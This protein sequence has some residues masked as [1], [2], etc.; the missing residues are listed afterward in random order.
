MVAAESLRHTTG[1][2]QGCAQQNQEDLHIPTDMAMS[3]G[4]R[5]MTPPSK[6]QCT[7]NICDCNS[8]AQ[9][10]TR[11]HSECC[12]SQGEENMCLAPYLRQT[13]HAQSC[14]F[15]LFGLYSR[16]LALA[17]EPAPKVP[18]SAFVNGNR[19]V[20]SPLPTFRG[21]GSSLPPAP[22]RDRS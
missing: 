2:L 21:R 22:R 20:Y 8:E 16:A 18:P 12:V 1:T 10:Q 17:A 11:T 15:T 3:T 13:Q 14:T 19:R 9:A 6:K 5:L 7:G 4:V